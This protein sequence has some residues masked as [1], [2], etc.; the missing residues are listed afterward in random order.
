VS[1]R[2]STGTYDVTL[3]SAANEQKIALI[4]AVKE[5]LGIGLTE[6]KS[7]V[8]NAPSL[9]KEGLSI[10]QALDL[11]ITLAKNGGVSTITAVGACPTYDEAT[12]FCYKGS[13]YDLCGGKEYDPTAQKCEGGA[14]LDCS[15]DVYLE[16]YGSSQ[17]LNVMKVVREYTGLGLAEAKALVD[18]AP[19]TLYEAMGLF[20]ANDFLEDLINAGATASL[21][22]STC[23]E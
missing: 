4:K 10:E 16:G 5:T 13:I 6:A 7:L 20:K 21:K 11:K 22:N 19:V 15:A 14:I 23:S 2:P 8:D 9:L 18:A 3:Q 1:L 12:T 17:K